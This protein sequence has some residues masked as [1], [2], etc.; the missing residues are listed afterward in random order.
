MANCSDS[1]SDSE[2]RGAETSASMR[3]RLL[4]LKQALFI[5]ISGL[6][7]TEEEKRWLAHR[8][9]AGVILFSRNYQDKTQLKALTAEIRSID[10][11]LLISVDHEGGRVQRFREGFSKLPPM[12]ELGKRYDHSK[13]A[14]LAEATQL[15]KL[16]ATELRAVGVDFSYAPVCDL[17]Y[18]VNP[19]IGDR[20]F[21]SDPTAV[22]QLVLA[23][24]E[25]VRAAGSIGVAK[26]FPG[27]GFVTIDTHIAI[28]Q[29]DR[30][31]S[32]LETHDL[33]PFR[34]LIDA[35]IEALMPAHII[36]TA[37]DSDNSVIASKKWLHY[38]RETL[39]FQGAIISDDLDMG[40]ATHLGRVSEKVDR[41]FA[42]GIDIV[43]LCND[44]Q[45]IREL[46]DG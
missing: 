12:R 42:A 31:L 41:C 29:D 35:G 15:G 27:H 10:Q 3:S 24:Y 45:A 40:G 33:K 20:A 23:F 25:G 8:D 16:M 43:L 6:K 17:D 37:L 4:G 38:L 2:K 46:L 14:A 32:Y 9:V 22:A 26:H 18:G 21:H 1:D 28:A 5:G 13:E 11:N 7:L 39:G 36:F 19:A 44:F 34:A 30:P